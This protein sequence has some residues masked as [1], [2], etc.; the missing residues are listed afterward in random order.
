MVPPLPASEHASMS[1]EAD[2][3]VVPSVLL[4]SITV[5]R[6]D[7]FAFPAGVF[8][9]EH[10]NRFALV[11]AGRDGLWWLQSA[12]RPDLVFLLADPFRYFPGYVVVVPPADLAQ[13]EADDQAT[14][15]ALAIVTLPRA[16]EVGPT[17]NLRA[18]VLLDVGRHVGRQVVLLDDSYQVRVPF[19]L[20]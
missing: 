4:D 1:S 9:F 15:M 11:P 13:L 20:G 6:A 10:C 8:G 12:D 18:P 3:I 16:E 17:A 7:L 14:L 19:A 2:T 5:R